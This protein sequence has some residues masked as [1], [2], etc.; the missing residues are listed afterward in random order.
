MRLTVNCRFVE[1]AKFYNFIVK[2][3]FFILGICSGIPPHVLRILNWGRHFKSSKQRV[4]N[5]QCDFFL[6]PLFY[7]IFFLQINRSILSD[8]CTMCYLWL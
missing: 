1:G 4:M 2:T 5:C 3:T 8:I 6:L 7:F